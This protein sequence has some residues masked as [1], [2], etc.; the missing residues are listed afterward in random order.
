MG[1]SFAASDGRRAVTHGGSP[2]LWVMC[3]VAGLGPPRTAVRPGFSRARGAQ[4]LR[5]WWHSSSYAAAF[6]VALPS[7]NDV[8]PMS[9]GL[10]RRGLD[11]EFGGAASGFSIVLDTWWVLPAWPNE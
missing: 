9:S 11:D 1:R 3:A 7:P 8:H 6:V 4:K 5:P 2:A 10:R